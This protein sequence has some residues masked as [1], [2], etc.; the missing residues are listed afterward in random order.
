MGDGKA[1]ILEGWFEDETGARVAT[2]PAGGRTTFAARV[3]FH[4]DVEDPLFGVVL[5]NDRRETVLAASNLWSNPASGNF[6]AGRETEYRVTFQNL[7][8][9]GRYQATPA[10]ARQGGGIAWLDRRE[11]MLSLLVSGLARTDAVVDLPYDVEI[12][13]GARAEVPS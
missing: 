13:P 4:E 3:R 10:V 1:E 2:V 7:L 11:R 9:P 5:Q 6:A 12:A 8:V